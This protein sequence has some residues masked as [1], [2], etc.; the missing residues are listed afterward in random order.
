MTAYRSARKGEKPFRGLRPDHRDASVT[1]AR[2]VPV[3]PG[4]EKART[5]V[6]GAVQ[7]ARRRLGLADQRVAGGERDLEG[8][9]AGGVALRG[10]EQPACHAQAADRKA[11]PRPL[12]TSLCV[13]P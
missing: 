13:L 11:P 7:D 10:I 2:G 5:V 3:R 6:R 8:Y 4:V 12:S 9:L 1:W